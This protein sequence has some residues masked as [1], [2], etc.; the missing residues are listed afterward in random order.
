MY[1][2]SIEAQKLSKLLEFKNI[3]SI[4]GVVTEVFPMYVQSTTEYTNSGDEVL[5]NIYDDMLLH[6][7]SIQFS[8]DELIYSADKDSYY[9]FSITDKDKLQVFLTKYRIKHRVQETQSKSMFKEI[10][11]KL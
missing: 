10:L 1:S 2:L 5:I 11:D 9:H 4:S 3:R 7:N 8:D 6:I